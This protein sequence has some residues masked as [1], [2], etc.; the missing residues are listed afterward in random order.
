M[1]LAPFLLVLASQLHAAAPAPPSAPL[2]APGAIFA[3]CTPTTLQVGGGAV[4]NTRQSIAAALSKAGPGSL[5][6]L[7]PGVYEAFSIGFNKPSAWNA[8]TSGGLP[9]QPVIVR[10]NGLV[11]IAAGKASDTIAISQALRCGHITFEGLTIEAGYRAGVMFYKC[12]PDQQ[13]EGFRFIDCKIFGGYDHTKAQGRTSKW[14]VWGHN[15]KDFEFRG[16]RAPAVV[17][18]IRQ[19]HAFYLQNSRG[20]ITLENVHAYRLGRT[21]AQFTARESDGAPGMGTIRVERCYVEDACI[22][23]GD[24]YKGGSAITLA[25]RHVGNVIFK[26]NVVRSGFV[27]D[28]L[29]LTRPPA[30]FGSG[31]F[32]AWDAGG[33]RNGLLQLENN[34]FEFAKGCGDRPLVQISGCR[35]VRLVGRNKFVSGGPIALWLDAD[36]S[37]PN[38]KFSADAATW[39]DGGDIRIGP[40]RV[41][42]EELLAYKGLPSAPPANGK[43]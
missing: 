11:T 37:N 43:K 32:V 15:L 9:S 25:G 14:G 5:I 21:F 30:P 33:Q 36:G 35:E 18:D 26:N 39:I 41:T 34:T 31:A 12:G 29:H 7:A 38:L 19:E 4:E 16:S 13:H 40:K 28:V 6:E 17:R 8:R 23:A 2:A 27:R 22:A 20:D 42:R 10:G 3:R 24:N 1:F